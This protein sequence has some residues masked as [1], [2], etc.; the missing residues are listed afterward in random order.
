M[1]QEDMLWKAM[2]NVCSQRSMLRHE[3]QIQ[4]RYS[5]INYTVIL[6]E[7]A[8]FSRRLNDSNHSKFLI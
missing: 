2:I 7:V 8:Y 4:I 5:N 1:V 3:I 6:D